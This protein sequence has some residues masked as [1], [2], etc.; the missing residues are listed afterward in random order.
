M[1]KCLAILLVMALCLTVTACRATP[2]A[3]EPQNMMDQYQSDS[4]EENAS[5]QSA[6]AMTEGVNAP[7]AD[8]ALDLF[9][10]S[11]GGEGNTLVS[12]LSVLSALTLVANGARGETL[13]QMESVL[14]MPLTMLNPWLS[15]YMEG[16]ED[17][18][19]MEMANAIWFKDTDRF[20]VNEDFLRHNADLFSAE[21]YKIPFNAQAVKTINDWVKEKT[22]GMIPEILEEIPEDAVM[23]LVNALAFE[24]QWEDA[25][26][27]YQVRNETFTLEN[28]T[29]QDAELMYRTEE[30]FILDEDARGFVKPYEGE[31]YAFVALLPNAGISVEEYLQSLNG[32]KLMT[33][34]SGRQR[35]EVRTAIPK[36][37]TEFSTEMSTVLQEMGMT[38]AFD[39]RCADFSGLGSS[40]YP[41][42]I[43]KVLHKTYI[44]IDEQGTKAAAVT[45]FEMAMG[46]AV[47][48]EKEVP[49]VILDRPFVYLI[50]DTET[51][52]PVFMGAMMNPAA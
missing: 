2:G 17:D 30:L 23:Y 13:T 15:G 47:G 4:L 51:N 9:R 46:A 33:L 48:I 45:A 44:S 7:M 35:T 42:Y 39:Y 20:T 34:L 22:Q 3:I 36:F 12:P 29:K 19:T 26:E 21:A 24:G 14:G 6:V 1:K 50:I 11:M 40:Q 27:D 41:L 28:G 8:F 16:L 25:Y 10:Q 38:D 37:E 43:S 49:E 32:E 18:D 31:K 52:Y 5:G